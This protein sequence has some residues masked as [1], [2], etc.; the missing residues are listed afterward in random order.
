MATVTLEVPEEVLTLV[1]PTP[2]HFVREMRLAAAAHWYQQGR[3]SQEK[4]AMVA[5]L[6]RADFL[7]ALAA[8][9]VDV[10]QVDFDDLA[11]ELKPA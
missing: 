1:P 9:G 4:A 11:R 8:L 3:I 5:G 2:E 10:F 6:D 7:D